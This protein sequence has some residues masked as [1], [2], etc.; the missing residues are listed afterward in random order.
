MNKAVVEFYGHD[1]D[2]GVGADRLFESLDSSTRK[3]R[4]KRALTVQGGDSGSP[5]AESVRVIDLRYGSD[6]TAARIAATAF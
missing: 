2:L 3:V 5:D 4:E 6:E 1:I